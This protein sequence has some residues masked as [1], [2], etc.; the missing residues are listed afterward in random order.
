MKQVEEQDGS[1]DFLLLTCYTDALIGQWSNSGDCTL[2]TQLAAM[3][4]STKPQLGV[5]TQKP[6]LHAGF[7]LREY[8]FKHSKYMF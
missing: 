2:N 6:T 8:R 5:V 7:N 3:L 1:G 4:T